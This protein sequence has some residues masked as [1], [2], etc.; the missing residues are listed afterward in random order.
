LFA[1]RLRPLVGLVAPPSCSLGGSVPSLARWLRSL[2]RSVAPVRSLVTLV[3]DSRALSEEG[4]LHR[5]SDAVCN[6][7]GRD[8]RGRSRLERCCNTDNKGR[9][10]PSQ[11][12]ERATEPTRGKPP[13]Q[14]GGRA[15]EPT[16]GSS[17][18]A[19]KGKEPPRQQ[20][21]SATEPTRGES[22]RGNKGK[23][24][25]S[26]QGEGATELTRGRSQRA[27]KG[28]E[29]PSQQR[30]TNQEQAVNPSNSG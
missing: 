7:V 24:P 18:R 28:R 2:V 1:R 12:G 15:T 4:Q 16:R 20:G 13:R 30:N 21:E 14:Q 29:P 19:N 5:L 25:P 9:E 8:P 27:D 17:H 3:D 23:E 22:H 11:Q 6:F 10:P 26:Q